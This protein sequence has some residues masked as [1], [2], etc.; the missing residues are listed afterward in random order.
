MK[1]NQCHTVLS[2]LENYG[3][4]NAPLCFDCAEKLKKENYIEN[5]S[6]KI[7]DIKEYEKECNN[8]DK[9]VKRTKLFGNIVFNIGFTIFPFILLV[10]SI[11]IYW[12]LSLLIGGKISKLEEYKVKLKA[13]K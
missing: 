1:C 4:D 5:K 2:F 13:I 9:K 11:A 6:E 12:L 8:I 10:L 7:E 3:N